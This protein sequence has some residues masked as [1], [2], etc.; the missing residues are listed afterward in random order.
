MGAAASVTVEDVQKL[1]QWKI[2]SEADV[3]LAD[4][5]KV[6]PKILSGDLDFK[7]VDPY[8]AYGG[9]YLGD[10]KDAPDFK[11]LTFNELPKVIILLFDKFLNS[12]IFKFISLLQHTSP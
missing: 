6:I 12:L 3:K 1:P 7:T 2:L 5:Q 11:Y 8:I 9:E 4:D 10:S